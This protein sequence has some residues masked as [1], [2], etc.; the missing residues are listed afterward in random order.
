RPRLEPLE[1]RLAPSNTPALIADLNPVGDSNPTS[2]A[3]LGGLVY[4]AA[5]SGS[6]VGEELWKTD[7]TSAGTAL[8]ADIYPGGGGFAPHSSSPRN[9]TAVGNTLFFSATD[10]STGVE[11]WK[12]DGTAAGT[13]QVK[14]I[15]LGANGSDPARLTAVSNT[16]YFT[17]T[18]AT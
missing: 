18:D 2:F 6:A 16:L 11:L 4:F 12:S 3:A 13:A 14:D 10:G 8:V 15:R 9:L 1:A 5:A 17:A 7:G